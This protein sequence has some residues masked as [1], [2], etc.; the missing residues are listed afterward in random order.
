MKRKQF[1]QSFLCELLIVILV[2][3]PVW[4]NRFP[5]LPISSVQVNLSGPMGLK[6][7]TFNGNLYYP[8]SELTIPGRGLSLAI[9]LAYNSAQ[10]L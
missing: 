5:T 3:N 2:V 1:R 9:D 4:A 7:N 10:R 8:H 6:V